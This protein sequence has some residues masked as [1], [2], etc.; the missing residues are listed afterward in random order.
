MPT[1]SYGGFL[2]A[3]FYYSLT[4]TVCKIII[5]YNNGKVGEAMINE[6]HLGVI[7]STNAYAKRNAS[8]LSLPALITASGQTQGRGR[9]DHSF[10]S[11]EST[12]LYMTFVF[13][14]NGEAELITPGAAVCVCRALEKN[15]GIKPGIKWVNDIFLE[16]KKICGIL[17]ENFIRDGRRFICIGIGINLTTADFPAELTQAGSVGINTD[18]RK[19]ARC[20]AE[21]L[22][23]IRKSDSLVIIDEYK[24]RLFILGKEICFYLDGSEHIGIAENINDECNLIVNENGR[25]ITL[26]CG[27]ISVRMR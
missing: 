13:E 15:F 21:E 4:T 25:I 17:T 3:Y 9:G 27:E 7:D 18:T 5:L 8:S 2:Q 6:I 20:I 19:L 11:P 24:S 22:E 16:G 12:G 14:A 26:N 10:Y 1:D 23:D